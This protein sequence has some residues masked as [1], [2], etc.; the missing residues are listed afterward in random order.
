MS[1]GDKETG[2]QTTT[3]TLAPGVSAGL[4]S[5]MNDANNLYKSGT[6][7]TP[8]GGATVVGPSAQTTAANNAIQSGVAPAAATLNSSFQNI[9]QIANG[10]GYNAEQND[11]LTQLRAYAN[12]SMS[13]MNN[14]AFQAVVKQGQTAAMDAVNAGASAAG[15]YGSG[16][17]QGN[18]AREVGDVT[19]RALANQMNIDT[20]N[21]LGAVSGLFSAGQQGTQNRFTAAGMLP[22]LYDATLDPQRALAG[23]GAQV[24][25]LAGRQQGAAQSYWQQQQDQK[26]SSIEW[27][28]ALAGGQGNLGGSTTT[29]GSK[30]G[31]NPFLAGLGGAAY[32]YDKSTEGNGGT[33]ALIG[34]GLGLLGS[35]F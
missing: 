34:G 33:G 10:T 5:A 2:K 19:N 23:V 26:R 7:F 24:E 20:Q 4:T 13:G 8:Y 28:A 6:M 11:A 21:Q 31:V 22:G 14:P 1:G 25:D 32:G 9:G 3:S 35:M 15:R 29:T 27:L 17:A 30:P 12:G 16:I 18:V